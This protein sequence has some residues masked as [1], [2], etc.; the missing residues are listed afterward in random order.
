MY[1]CCHAVWVVD[2]WY[3]HWPVYAY[4][5]FFHMGLTDIGVQNGGGAHGL[6]NCPVMKFS[7]CCGKVFIELQFK[8]GCSVY[9]F[10]INDFSIAIT[11]GVWGVGFYCYLL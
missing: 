4:W 8:G 3:L 7:V 6:C 11:H 1:L 9:I 10:S 5:Y 2:V